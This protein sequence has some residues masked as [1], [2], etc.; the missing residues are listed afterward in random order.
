MSHP[1]ALSPPRPAQPPDPVP[2]AA[3]PF[4]AVRF[5]SVAETVEAR[6][7]SA[8]AAPVVPSGQVDE[9]L[10]ADLLELRRTVDALLDDGSA[11][12]PGRAVLRAARF[13]AHRRSSRLVHAVLRSRSMARARDL[14]RARHERDL[15]FS[16]VGML[17]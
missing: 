11:P 15:L 3:R 7:T 14:E 12:E 16:G 17:R 6:E 9:R 13:L 2:G 5:A 10:R 1:T 4:D 8:S